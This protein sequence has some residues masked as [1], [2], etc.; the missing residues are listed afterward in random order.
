[1]TTT[2]S[3]YGTAATE[4]TRLAVTGVCKVVG[5]E[6]AAKWCGGEARPPHLFTSV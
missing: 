6:R 4:E 5:R 2:T 1:M 3:D